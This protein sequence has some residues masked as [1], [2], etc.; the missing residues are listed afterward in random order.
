MKAIDETVT[1]SIRLHNVADVPVG[2]FLSE[3]VDSSYVTAVLKPK[4]V[5]SVNFANGPFDEASVA[6]ELADEKGLNFNV[7]TVDGDEAFH[8]FAE[9]Q[10]HLDE[11]DA[12]PS[13]I[14]LWYLCRM[15][16][17]KVTVALSGEG[18]DELFA[19]YVNYGM[20]T[21]KRGHQGVR[22]R[23]EQAA[24]RRALFARPRHQEAAKLPGQGA[25]V[26]PHR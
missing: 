2:S 19:G 1:E 11:P 7:E 16:R 24:T 4:E 17:R 25:P 26:H 9:M 6:K 14:P 15:A 21:K 12:N 3:G 18:A 20:H 23:L 13:V 8:D 5:F 22:Q 10:Y